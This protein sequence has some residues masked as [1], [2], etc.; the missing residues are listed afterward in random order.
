MKRR[1]LLLGLGALFAAPAIV[2]AASLMPVS[3]LKPKLLIDGLDIDVP[4]C[5]FITVGRQRMLW[6]GQ[7]WIKW[8]DIGDRLTYSDVSDDV[9][10]S[11]P[12]RPDAVHWS[13]ALPQ[14]PELRPRWDGVIYAPGMGDQGQIY[15]SVIEPLNRTGGYA[16]SDNF[17]WKPWP[18]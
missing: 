4:D 8:T 18:G 9:L 17:D 15:R 13:E 1:G 3:V 6:S 12:P 14:N 16:G 2:R 11:G 7:N 5:L 10:P